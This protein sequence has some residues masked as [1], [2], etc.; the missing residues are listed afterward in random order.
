[1]RGLNP[2][3]ATITLLLLV[4]AVSALVYVSVTRMQGSLRETIFGSWTEAQK[5]EDAKLSLEN[6][7]VMDNQDSEDDL[8]LVIKN[9]G[10]YDY[11]QDE[12]RRLA[13]Y[14][15]DAPAKM[16]YKAEVH[17]APTRECGLL[18]Q[19]LKAG[20]TLLVNCTTAYLRPTKPT[21]IRIEMPFG[22]TDS[23]SFKP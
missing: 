15:D 14:F 13:V 2:I 11:V 22:Q 23:R 6:M 10:K 16:Y 18:A 9:S 8:V 1:M 12:M 17:N 20:T 4:I 3:V 5:R 7:Y 19:S 21:D